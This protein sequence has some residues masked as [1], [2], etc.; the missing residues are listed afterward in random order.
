MIASYPAPRKIKRGWRRRARD[1]ASR[2]S[3]LRSS[4]FVGWVL[5]DVVHY[6]RLFRLIV[7]LTI[8]R[9]FRI[10]VKLVFFTKTN[11]NSNY[12]PIIGFV[13]VFINKGPKLL[14]YL[15]CFCCLLSN[16]RYLLCFSSCHTWPCRY[17]LLPIDSEGKGNSHACAFVPNHRLY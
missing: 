4:L 5:C 3:R 14:H 11:S 17:F 16:I 7:C 2:R 6:S 8:I 13:A 12:F 9:R 15:L 1:N 10:G